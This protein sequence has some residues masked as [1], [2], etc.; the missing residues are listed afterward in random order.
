MA[1]KQFKSVFPEK[2]AIIGM[3]HVKSLPGTPLYDTSGGMENLVQQALADAQRLLEAGVDGIQIE[4][5]WDRPFVRSENLG[6]ETVAVLTHITTRISQIA[7]IPL[8]IN[9]HLNCCKEA[10]AVAKATGCGWIRA[11]QLSNAYIANAGYVEAAGPELMRYRSAI[12]AEDVMVFG[13]FQVKHG[14]H[15]LTADRSII[16]K[17]ADIQDMLAHAAIITGTATGTPPDVD[18]C[19]QV[20]KHIEIPLLIGSGLSIDNLE[21]IWPHVDGAIVGS[22]FKE[23]GVLANPISTK[24]VKEFITKARDIETK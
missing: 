14:S 12:D 18:T 16:E 23:D 3:V 22:S 17:A 5:Q 2:K 11:F 21:Q 4:N 7:D 8:G 13:D 24:R 20:K 10:L 1:G 6:P 9:I 19:I 15:A